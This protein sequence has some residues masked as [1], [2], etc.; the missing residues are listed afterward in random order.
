MSS[1]IVESMDGGK[2]IRESRDVDVP[3][4]AAHFF[5][6]AGWADKLSYGMGGRAVEPLGV[7]GADRAVELPAA[8]GGLEAGAGARVR[9]H[10]GAEARGDHAGH[11]PAARRDP[12]GGGA[13]AGRGSD[14]PGRRGGRR[15]AG[16]RARHRQGRLHRLD[17]RRQGHP[18]GARRA[19]HPADA[20]AGRQVGQHR[21]RGRR[22]RP[23]GRGDRERHLLQPGPRLL[24]RLAAAD[25]GERGRDGRLEAVGPHGPAARGRPARQEHRR[26]RDQLARAARADHGARGERRG[27]GRGAAERGRATCPSAATGSRRRCSPTSR[28]RTASPPRRSS[29]RSSRC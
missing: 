26:G 7:A 27:G 12:P 21:V 8:D 18:G 13:A 23:G 17:L 11:R 3:L 10:G 14:R 2:P 29:A 16:A 19:R 22:A 28:R 1:P 4:A 24:R 20:R 6:Y 15:H 9:Q 5:H 25:P